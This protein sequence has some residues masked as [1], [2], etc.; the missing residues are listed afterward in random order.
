MQITLDRRLRSRVQKRAE[1]LGVPIAEYVR[2]AIEKD[3]GD[4][5][6]RVPVSELFDLGRSKESTD[7]A[8]DKHKMIADAIAA[9]KLGE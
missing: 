6:A 7:I 9:A 3:L 2:Q 4:E 1:R 8:R 5:P